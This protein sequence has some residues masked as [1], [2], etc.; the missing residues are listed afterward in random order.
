[1]ARITLDDP[2]LY[3]NRHLQWILFNQRVLEEARDQG[4]ALLE[5]VEFLAIT[6]NNLDEFVEIR[7]SSF[8]P[9]VHQPGRAYTIRRTGARIRV[10]AA[11]RP[12]AV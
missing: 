12:R 9:A 7:V 1:M 2:R 11:I 10:D 4:N 8:R 3:L 5:R 6:A